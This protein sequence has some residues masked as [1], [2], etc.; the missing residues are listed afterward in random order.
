MFQVG[1]LYVSAL[2]NALHQSFSSSPGGFSSPSSSLKLSTAW[3]LL[4]AEDSAAAVVSIAASSAANLS[5]SSP[6][7]NQGKISPN[8]TISIH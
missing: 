2:I 4:A 3:P 6:S 5:R 7:E 1:D 8:K